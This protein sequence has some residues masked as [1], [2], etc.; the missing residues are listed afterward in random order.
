[1]R[2]DSLAS[3][4]WAATGEPLARRSVTVVCVLYAELTFKPIPDFARNG[5][6]GLAQLINVALGHVP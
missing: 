2:Q 3:P 5:T 6:F 1:M 4:A